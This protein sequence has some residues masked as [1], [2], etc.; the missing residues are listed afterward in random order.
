MAFTASQKTLVYELLGL[1]QGGTYNWY[2]YNSWITG[3]IT[4]A[5]FGNSVDF[6][7]AT[8]VLDDNITTIE[9]SGDNREVRIGEIL[10]AYNDISLQE[11]AIG[12]GG[13]CN[14]EGVRYNTK[15]H[16]DKLRDLLEQHVGLHVE[17]EGI[18]GRPSMDSS[19]GIAVGR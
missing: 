11:I 4:S 14:T 12:K 16:T 3:Q 5:P 18:P 2:D 9:A 17:S 10:S 15:A 1:Y 8:S 7:T 6:S 19:N 13:S